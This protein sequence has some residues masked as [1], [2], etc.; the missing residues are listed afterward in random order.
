MAEII[1]DVQEYLNYEC[2]C[3][4]EGSKWV[5]TCPGCDMYKRGAALPARIEGE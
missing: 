4:F 2:N 3:V 5:K 1:D